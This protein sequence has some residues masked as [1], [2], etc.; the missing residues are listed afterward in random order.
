MAHVYGSAALLIGYLVLANTTAETSLPATLRHARR[1]SSTLAPTPEP[2]EAPPQAPTL[3]LSLET[4]STTKPW[5]P[6]LF[7]PADAVSPPSLFGQGSGSAFD[8]TKSVD[9]KCILRTHD[10]P[11]QRREC[12]EAPPGYHYSEELEKLGNGMCCPKV[13][14]LVASVDTAG[15]AQQ[16]TQVPTQLAAASRRKVA[17]PTF[18]PTFDPTAHP[19]ENPT[20]APTAAP[21]SSTSLPATRATCA[22]DPT[23]AN[24]VK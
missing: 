24:A 11:S 12:A 18:E 20:D 19:S 14:H 23:A 6:A 3:A 15:P 9:D 17:E 8:H 13:C 4:N 7:D 1:S 2:T 5:S 10:C 21:S 22:N 16:P